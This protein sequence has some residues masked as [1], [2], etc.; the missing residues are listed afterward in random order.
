MAKTHAA[1][2]A[3]LQAWDKSDLTYE[4]AYQRA[5]GIHIWG[6]GRCGHTARGSGFCA[7]C[8]QG[9]IERRE[10]RNG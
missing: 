3:E 10:R 5:D 1:F 8:L 6:P 4:L 2:R 9:E 7:E